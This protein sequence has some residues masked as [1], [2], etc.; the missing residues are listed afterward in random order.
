MSALLSLKR[1]GA[2][3]ALATA[4]S[5]L[6]LPA[7]AHAV[8][9]DLPD[10]VQGPPTVYDGGRF[11]DHSIGGD[12]HRAWD[13]PGSGQEPFKV[14]F[15]SRVANVGAGDLEICGYRT[16]ATSQWMNAYQT[17]T[18]ALGLGCGN[19]EPAAGVIGVFR[20]V[21]GNHGGF[22]AWHLMDLQRFALVPLPASAGGPGS[23]V[24]TVWDTRWG[25][26]LRLDTVYR[27][28]DTDLTSPDQPLVAGI[29][30]GATKTTQDGAPDDEVIAFPPAVRNELPD[31]NYQVVGIVNPYGRLAERGSGLNVNCT[32]IRI[33]GI[34]AALNVQTL[35]ATPAT[36]WV[37]QD[38]P[39][40]VSSASDPMTG[41]TASTCLLND[42]GHCWPDPP[43]TPPSGTEFTPA[44]TNITGTPT[45][46]NAVPV[47]VRAASV[48]TPAPPV[49][50]P[51]RR[52]STGRQS[53]ASG[54]VRHLSAR[55]SRSYARTA[56]RKQFGR[57]LRGLKVSCRVR[58]STA[59]TCKVSYR[60]A[61]GY[62]YSG[63]VW[64]RYKTVKSR[65][66]WQY[67][68]EIN[69]RKRHHKTQ[70]IHRGYRTGGTF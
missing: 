32:T 61:N 20:Y 29:P 39:P 26:C 35:D 46:T 45:A 24:P 13:A 38:R 52:I 51:P 3:L 65:L 27:D 6:A 19:G 66:R 25:N 70:K 37:P 5:C 53:A 42:T 17:S 62:R 28:C 68:M 1:H 14:A 11:D 8:P 10:L 15:T 16:G 7:A 63:H 47:A 33:S 31:G 55:T 48:Q 12:D 60:K 30:A 54:R 18:D 23:S 56:L 41:Q 40:Q 57:H 2:R 50:A 58:H 4:L 49:A 34:P 69:K 59:A 43:G 44:Q 9:G 64:L 22:N 36:C 21:I 67:R